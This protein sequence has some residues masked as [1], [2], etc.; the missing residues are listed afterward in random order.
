MLMVFAS[1]LYFMYAGVKRRKYKTLWYKRLEII[2]C[3]QHVLIRAGL[4]AAILFA[5][6]AA[7]SIHH[8]P[9]PLAG[10]GGPIIHWNSS[11]IYAAENNAYPWGPVGE[12]ASFKSDTYPPNHHSTLYL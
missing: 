5:V 1:T 9:I 7:V 8:A 4:L 2:S 11:M 10:G 12:N 3:K 6:Q